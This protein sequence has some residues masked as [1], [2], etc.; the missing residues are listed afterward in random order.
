MDLFIVSNW[1]CSCEVRRICQP[2]YIDDIFKFSFYLGDKDKVALL[3][4]FHSSTSIL[5]W[6]KETF[7][8]KGW[9]PHYYI[10]TSDPAGARQ[11]SA[12]QNVCPA[13]V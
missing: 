3:S 8:M 5:S 11:I 13:M 2:V 12:L 7:Y 10:V 1:I 6:S 4:T 9:S